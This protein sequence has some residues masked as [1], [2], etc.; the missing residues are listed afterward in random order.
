MIEKFDVFSEPMPLPESKQALNQRWVI[1]RKRDQNGNI[2]NYKARLTP[3]ES[4]ETFVVDF[5]DTYAPVARITTV[6]FVF[7]LA[8]LLSLHVSGIDFTNA[9][10]IAPLH[11]DIYVNAPPGCVQAKASLI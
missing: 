7:A 4:F 10:L 2:V 9:I 1:K 11:D 6:R 8:V 5:M 3:Q